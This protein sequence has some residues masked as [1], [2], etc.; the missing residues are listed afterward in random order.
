[1]RVTAQLIDGTKGNH[2]WAEHYDRQL[3]NTF[4][5]QDEITFKILKELHVKLSEGEQ[6]RLYSNGT[7]N[8]DAYLKFWQ[9]RS[10]FDHF[11]KGS[12]TLARQIYEEVIV[13]DPKWEPPYSFLGFTH[14]VDAAYGYNDNPEE[15]VKQAFQ[16]AQKA[17]SLNESPMAHA[18][19][20]FIYLLTRQHD[21]ALEEGEKNIALFPNSAD[22]YAW[23]AQSLFLAGEPTKAISLTEKALRMNPFP[24]SWYYNALFWGYS[25]LRD[26][27]RAMKA[28]KKAI[29]IEPTSIRAHLSLIVSFVMLGFEKEAYAQAQE[30]LNINPSF[31]LERLA[32]GLPFKDPAETERVLDALRKAGLN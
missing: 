6:A 18:L 7:E 32:K 23:H 27:E 4:A 30:V 21:K 15:S 19:L 8:I 20:S 11:D 25:L 9:G 10:Y 24:P 13:L 12:N 14:W 2:L 3:E 26:Y 22:A 28:S 1:V 31:S 29:N 5:I 17:I 16:C